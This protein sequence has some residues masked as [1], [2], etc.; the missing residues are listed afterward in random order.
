MT[1]S[2]YRFPSD[3][4]QV[5]GTNGKHVS[6]KL[7]LGENIGDSGGVKASFGVG[8]LV[9]RS[10]NQAYKKFLQENGPEPIL[11]KLGNFTNEQVFFMS[12]GQVCFYA[13]TPIVQL[14]C[15]YKSPIAVLNS[16]ND[17]HAPQE[18]R[19]NTV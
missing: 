8:Q 2:R 9:H 4:L 10:I 18:N 5:P 11:K 13:S 17:V 14:Y 3:Q 12:F 15:A 6:G 19:I 16:I 7:T 1:P